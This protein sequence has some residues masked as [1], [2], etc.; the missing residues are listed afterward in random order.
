MNLENTHNDQKMINTLN[1]LL[2]KDLIN[3][4]KEQF[5]INID[6][7]NLQVY[8]VE[9]IHLTLH[10]F[11]NLISTGQVT[12]EKLLTSLIESLNLFERKKLSENEAIFVSYLLYEI[13]EITELKNTDYQIVHWDSGESIE[14]WY[15]LRDSVSARNFF[16]AKRLLDIKPDL[17]NV[18]NL[19][20]E[21]VLHFLA[22]ENDI[23]GV[24]WLHQQGFSLD[25]K[26]AIM[27][28]PI[29]FEIASL[30]YK[31]LLTWFYQNG[32]DFTAKD[33]AQHN[34]FEFLKEYESMEVGHHAD[35]IEYMHS[36]ILN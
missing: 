33:S 19:T 3:F 6:D 23:E 2:N 29:I 24:A 14:Y 16:E 8:L 7:S 22:V 1:Q 36:L 10:K 28:E 17:L 31:D 4:S 35:M 12:Q 11:L 9:R 25:N 30:G 5:G 20:G 18:T 32:A 34:I 13:C 21:T 15:R 26:T 27:Q